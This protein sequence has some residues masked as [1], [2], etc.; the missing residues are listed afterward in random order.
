MQPLNATLQ[1][2]S[3]DILQAIVTRGEIDAVTL[4]TLE[5]ATIGK[6][7]LCVHT[8]RLDLQN[9]LLHLLHS[10]ISASTS[11]SQSI[12][13][14]S[15]KPLRHDD[16]LDE[17]RHP[18][19][20][21]A[22]ARPINPLLTQT[23]VDGVTCLSN[24]PVLQHWLDFILMALPQFN[25]TLQTVVTPMNECV[26]R[27]L[28]SF[29]VDFVET[30]GRGQDQLVDT[31]ATVTDAEVVMVL[32]ALERL[33]LLGLANATEANQTDDEQ[34]IPDKAGPDST[35]LL[36]YVSNVFGSETAAAVV[37]EQLSVSMPR[38]SWSWL[39]KDSVAVSRLPLTS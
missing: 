2:T 30:P 39:I 38:D 4:Y 20:S 32:N 33:I 31:C 11:A 29:L 19:V 13:S 9:K 7:F 21:S 23:L 37:E 18:D 15:H 36:G 26:C 3:V 34:P 10:L 25:S 24:R 8:G 16:A 28:R 35:G 27:L 1:S 6:L 5:A 22:H 12:S 14:Q 17:K